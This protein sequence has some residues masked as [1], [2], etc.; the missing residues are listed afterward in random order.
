MKITEMKNRF[1]ELINRFPAELVDGLK[2]TEQNPIWHPEIYVYNHIKIVYEFACE[3][4]DND[5]I[6][7]ALFHDL[8][9]I[10]TTQL[11][12]KDG[13]QKWVSY[14]HEIKSLP[15][16]EQYFY[17]FSDISTNIEKVRSITENHMRAHLYLKGEMNKK[18]KSFENLEYFQDIMTF[19]KCDSMGKKI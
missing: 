8:G 5:L 17:L 11:I 13:K 14:G 10:C 16:I 4:G 6:I 2:N 1:E 15:Y 3:T 7:A 12:T 19:E 18:A 9:K